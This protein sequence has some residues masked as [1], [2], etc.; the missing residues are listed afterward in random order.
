MQAFEK[1][2][3]DVIEGTVKVESDAEA[4][5]DQF[6]RNAPLVYVVTAE[7]GDLGVS[8]SAPY[9]DMQLEVSE[10][11]NQAREDEKVE[12]AITRCASPLIGRYL[13][14]TT[15]CAAACRPRAAVNVVVHLQGCFVRSR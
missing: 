5:V 3:S 1:C 7:T 11:L 12:Q 10:V 4:L 15:E 9:T 8:F 2:P 6:Q 14:P 13:V